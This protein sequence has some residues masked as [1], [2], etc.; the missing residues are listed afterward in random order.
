M[1]YSI[2]WLCEHLLLEALWNPGSLCNH[3]SSCVLGWRLGAAC[4]GKPSQIVQLLLDLSAAQSSRLT[5]KQLRG[6]PEVFN[7]F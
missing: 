1:L 5:V 4:W 3:H 6:Q 7:V 2:V